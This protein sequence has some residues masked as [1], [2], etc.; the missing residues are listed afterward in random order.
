M[1]IYIY[2][3]IYIY[4]HTHIYYRPNIYTYMRMYIFTNRYPFREEY[5]VTFFIKFNS[6]GIGDEMDM[7]Y[8]LI[9]LPITSAFKYN[10]FRI[11]VAR[12]RIQICIMVN[13]I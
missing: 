12:N 6:C 8:Q 5:T 7:N 9:N 4:T 1:Y 2:I 11:A 10:K 13:D 3:Y